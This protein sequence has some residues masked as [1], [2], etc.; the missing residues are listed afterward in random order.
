MAELERYADCVSAAANACRDWQDALRVSDLNDRYLDLVARTAADEYARVEISAL[1][2]QAA[3][4][5]TFQDAMQKMGL[6][7]APLELP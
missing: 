5:Q 2:D 6:A 4:A 1:T 7:A 3:A